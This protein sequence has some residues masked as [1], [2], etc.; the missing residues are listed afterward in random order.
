M[1]S[2]GFIEK[3][4]RAS[5]RLRAL[6]PELYYRLDN[7]QLSL[8]YLFFEEDISPILNIIENKNSH[9]TYELLQAYVAL[10][11]SKIINLRYYI[12][13][14]LQYGGYKLCLYIAQEQTLPVGNYYYLYYVDNE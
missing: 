10:L 9:D 2:Y 13:M 7:K 6:S 12:L 8:T 3:L 1:S 14:F 11:N 4:D 5:R